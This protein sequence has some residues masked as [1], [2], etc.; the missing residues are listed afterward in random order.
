MKVEGYFHLFRIQREIEAQ[1]IPLL[2][3]RGL[4]EMTLAQATALIAVVQEREPITAAR[5]AELLHVSPVTVSRI[6]AKLEKQRW[7]RRRP[8]PEDARALLIGPTAKTR[9]SL[10]LFLEVANAL[11]ERAYAGYSKEEIRTIVELLQRTVE[12]LDGA[13]EEE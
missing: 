10:P 12:N 6:V 3:E 9:R 1:A 4:G 5:L 8:H 7:I 11:I 2:R 13:D